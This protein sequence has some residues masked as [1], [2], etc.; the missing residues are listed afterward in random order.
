MERTVDDLYQW[1]AK[2]DM[3][4]NQNEKKL[5]EMCLNSNKHKIICEKSEMILREMK[6][7]YLLKRVEERLIEQGEKAK[8]KNEERKEH[9]FENLSTGNQSMLNNNK[10]KN[11]ESRYNKQKSNVK[12]ENDL[13]YQI[14]NNKRINK[15]KKKQKINVSGDYS[16]LIDIRKQLN[17]YYDN[18]NKDKNNCNLNNQNLSKSNRLNSLNEIMHFNINNTNNHN[19]YNPTTKSFTFGGNAQNNNNNSKSCK[20][21]LKNESDLNENKQKTNNTLVTNKNCIKN[22]KYNFNN[23]MKT[24]YSFLTGDKPLPTY[25]YQPNPDYQYSIKENNKNINLN[26]I[27]PPHQSSLASYENNALFCPPQQINYQSNQNVSNNLYNYYSQKSNTISYCDYTSL[28]NRHRLQ[29]LEVMK[30]FAL[31]LNNLNTLAKEN[32]IDK[33]NNK[34]FNYCDY[35]QKNCNSYPLQQNNEHNNINEN[36]LQQENKNENKEKDNNVEQDLKSEE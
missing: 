33:N 25:Q 6:N 18:K 24:P 29:D 23:Q 2:I 11:V 8:V 19:L 10:Y 3:K 7:D 14:K 4:R 1:K 20:M 27:N 17:N 12:N 16:S 13:S 22:D 34:Q 21:N 26:Q 36:T 35:Y 32:E 31:N 15:T 28:I 5:N 30:N 9:Y